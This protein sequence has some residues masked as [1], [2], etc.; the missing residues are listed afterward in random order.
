MKLLLLLTLLLSNYS[1]HSQTYVYSYRLSIEKGVITSRHIDSLELAIMPTLFEDHIGFPYHDGYYYFKIEKMVEERGR[2][3]RDHYN[4][5][6]GIRAHVDTWLGVG[7]FFGNPYSIRIN[8]YGSCLGCLQVKTY[9]TVWII[10]M[11]FHT[12][13]TINNLR[14]F[15]FTNDEHI[16]SQIKAGKQSATIWSTISSR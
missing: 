6:T 13:S 16:I 11:M 14:A 4:R 15:V 7:T 5:R 10:P 12:K 9:T 8:E 3:N 1:L 2:R